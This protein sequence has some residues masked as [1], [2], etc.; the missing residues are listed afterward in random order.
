[1]QIKREK[2]EFNL[3]ISLKRVRSLVKERMLGY[4]GAKADSMEEM[5]RMVVMPGD[6][7][8]VEDILG[9]AIGEMLAL[10]GVRCKS[11]GRASA[12]LS[13]GMSLP[14][15]MEERRDVVECVWPGMAE[16]WLAGRCVKE[17]RQHHCGEAGACGGDA[18]ESETDEQLLSLLTPR[19]IASRR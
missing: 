15:R 1:M 7:E 8:E 9:K 19:A 14:C 13:L 10:L 16:E 3:K 6:E 12:S 17:W 2:S 11:V 5:G 18:V 4:A